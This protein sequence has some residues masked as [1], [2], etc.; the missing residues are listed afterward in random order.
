MNVRPS[1]TRLPGRQIFSVQAAKSPK[2]DDVYAV[3]IDTDALAKA[4]KDKAI[5]AGGAVSVLAHSPFSVAGSVLAPVGYERKDFLPVIS[6]ERNISIGTGAILGTA[7]QLVKGAGLV[8][9]LLIGGTLGAVV[10]GAGVTL[11]HHLKGWQPLLL[12]NIAEAKGEAVRTTSGSRVRKAGA[13]LRMG[14]DSGF[15]TSWSRGTNTVETAT[16]VTGDFVD[17]F[18]NP[19]T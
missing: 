13:A 3:S 17:G 14:L 12:D 15:S 16:E 2:G 8:N 5:Q 18:M 10:G 11:G 1:G 7:V 9:A 6:A 19:G 4:S